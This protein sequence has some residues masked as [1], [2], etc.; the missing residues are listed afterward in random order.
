MAYREKTDG[1]F[2][3]VEGRGRVV[4]A[5]CR[6][7]VSYGEDAVCL[8]TA[9]GTVTVYGQHLVMG[10][11]TAEGATVAGSITRVEFQ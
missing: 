4:L 3:E 1:F 2:M 11:M 8:R 9:F 7:I 5:G 6:G 10:C